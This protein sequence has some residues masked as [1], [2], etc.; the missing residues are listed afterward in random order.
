MET[1][2]FFRRQAVFYLRLSD[3]CCD[4]LIADYLRSKAAEYHHSALRAEFSSAM[5]QLGPTL[6]RHEFAAESD[7]RAPPAPRLLPLLSKESQS[8]KQKMNM[9]LLEDV[10]GGVLKAGAGGSARAA[11]RGQANSGGMSPMLMALMAYLAY[12]TLS[13]GKSGAG[14]PAAPVDVP[15]GAGA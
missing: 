13:G 12:R 8:V 7:E 5:S 14:A 2:A 9:G 4:D 10:I 1:S 15:G 6:A 3:F 11:P